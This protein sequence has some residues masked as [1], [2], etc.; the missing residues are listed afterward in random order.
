MLSLC[1]ITKNEAHCIATMLESA[2]PIADEII[3][4]DTGSTD[5]TQSI[6]QQH[7]A[8]VVDHPWRDDFSEARN[9]SLARA[10]QP[11]ILVLD[12]DEELAV[13]SQPELRGLLSAEPQAFSVRRLH[14]CSELEARAMFPLDINHPAR[15]RG[16]VAFFSTTDY[17]LF[18]NDPKIRFRG[19]I[20]ESIE[21]AAAQSSL[22]RTATS[23][24]VNHYGHLLSA[25]K[26]KAKA[27]SYL[28]LAR[29]N[30]E[31]FPEDWR[32][33][34]YL[35]AEYQAQGCFIEARGAFQHALSMID[36]YSPLWRELGITL[37]ICGEKDEALKALRRALS[38]NPGCIL[39]W[40]ALGII[41]E[42]YGHYSEAQECFE[43]VLKLDAGNALATE[44]LALIKKRATPK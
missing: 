13:V 18:P 27:A 36:T 17:R 15:N 28:F 12:A 44:N 20:H 43:T 3:V 35:G 40:N 1:V 41:L 34:Y 22:S 5:G 42:H 26:K 21:D 33:W 29:K 31:Q 16:A 39:S 38:I 6:A 4:V 24:Q 14:F 32:T 2:R 7:G 8:I 37:H 9:A 25:D 23:I 19:V 10:T 30:T 11:W